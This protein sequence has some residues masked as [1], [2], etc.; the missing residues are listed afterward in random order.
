VEV[1]HPHTKRQVAYGPPLK[2]VMPK[3]HE[4]VSIIKRELEQR[5]RV[6]VY[7]QNSLST[8]I[9]PRIVSMLEEE[10]IRVKVLRSGETEG[11]RLQIFLLELCRCHFL[12]NISD[13]RVVIE[14]VKLRM[15]QKYHLDISNIQHHRKTD[16]SAIKL[17]QRKR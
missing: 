6:M 16:I 4:F 1:I 14:P 8:D 11:R 7:F 2:G 9:S 5:R 3:E 17:N 12:P 10:N 15:S 13:G